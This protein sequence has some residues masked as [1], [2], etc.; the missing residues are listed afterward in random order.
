MK[1]LNSI[2]DSMDRN[3]SKLWELVRKAW[4]VAIHG[5]EDSQTLLRDSTEL[6]VK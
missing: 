6:I 1:L 3:L 5:V 4:Y 2:T